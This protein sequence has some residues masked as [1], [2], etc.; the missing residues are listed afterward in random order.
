MKKL[1][2][3]LDSFKAAGKFVIAY[4]TAYSQKTYYLAS[5]A[6]KVYLHPMG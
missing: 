1:R 2:E 6:D 3:S 4:G 5:A